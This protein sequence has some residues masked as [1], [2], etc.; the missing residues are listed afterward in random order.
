MSLDP[1]TLKDG[2]R[3]KFGGDVVKEIWSNSIK[4]P[5]PEDRKYSFVLF[6]DGFSMY[7]TDSLWK[8]AELV[9]HCLPRDLYFAMI[10]RDGTYIVW[11]YMGESCTPSK[12]LSLLKHD[13]AALEAAGVKEEEE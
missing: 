7:Y 3:I 6:K 10:Q 4:L 11:N 2:D 5:H 8:I 12:F 13:V 1:S 9:K